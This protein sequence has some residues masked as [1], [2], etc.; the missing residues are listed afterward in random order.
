MAVVSPNVIRAASAHLAL[1]ERD[2]PLAALARHL[3]EAAAGSG[4][5]V[6]VRGEAGIGKTALLREFLRTCPSEIEILVGACDGVSTPQPFG[7]LEDM[8]ATLGPDLRTLLD[9][10]ASRTEVGRWLLGRLS[11][12]GPYVVAIEDLQ[13]ADDATL[14]LL[15][16]FARRLEGLDVLVL[17][18]IRDGDPSTPSVARILG[19]IAALP[20]VRQLPLEPLTRAGVARLIGRTTLDVRELHRITAGNPFYATEVLNGETGDHGTIPLSILDAVRAR[21]DRLDERGR[22]A[23]QVAA[24]IGVRSEPWLLAAIA[25]EDLVGIDDGLGAGLLV[26]ADDG[27]AFRHELTRMAILEDLP[28]IRGIALHRKALASLERVGAVDAARLA[29]HAEGAADSVAVL[30]HARAAGTRAL[31]MGALTEA[32]AQF[33]RAWRYADGLPAEDRAELLESLSL[34]L[35]LRNELGE[36]YEACHEAIALRR[37][38]LDRTMMAADLSFL[39]IVAWVYGRGAEAWQVAREAVAILEPL[40]DSRPLALA[41]AAVGRLGLSAGIAAE[42]LATSERAVEIGR[43]VGDPESVAIGLAT[44]GTLEINAGHEAAGRAKLE[45]SLR[46]GREA[47]LPVVV[48]RAL[49]NLGVTAQTGRRFGE[50]LGFFTE[51]EEY[52]ERS[53]IERCSIYAPRAEIGLATGAW[54][55]AEVD[56]RAAFAAPRTDPLDR[57]LAMI[58]LAQIALRRG[59]GDSDAWLAEPKELAVA[60]WTTQIRWPLAAVAAERVWLEG[61][62]AAALVEI[63]TAY[64]EACVQ[65]DAWPIG[66]LGIWLWRLG[67]IAELDEL[68]PEPYRLESSGHVREAAAA[69]EALG[70]PFDAA[71][72][73]AGSSDPDDV[74]RAHSILVE[75]GATAVAAKVADRLRAIGAAVPRGPRPATR[76]NANG[77]TEREVEIALLLAS[78]LSNAEIAARLVLSRKTVGHHVS[79]ILGKLDVPR[80]G[81]VAAAM[82]DAPAAR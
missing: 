78:G 80:R 20:V 41:F 67:G 14:E 17:V 25:G 34:V 54:A 19:S 22:R 72:S 70:I 73:L 71:L 42:G 56:A 23:L 74:R 31:A 38:A 6:V 24:I 28:V 53:E 26:K 13:W 33:R 68:A 18:T 63:R 60:M 11:T 77:L 55:A 21:V 57:A 61:G 37:S 16:W 81:A 43:R 51:L 29:Y 49:N 45:E 64:D 10:N 5:F 15:A 59:Q 2:E 58:V 44:I 8:V 62:P 76:A 46:I 3:T 82:R 32:T 50:A 1:I 65:R 69:W 66:E 52:S 7:P 35:Y 30:R 12:G 47:G 40:G 9:A 27:I 36:S 4:R 48:D 75:L 39:S 79:A